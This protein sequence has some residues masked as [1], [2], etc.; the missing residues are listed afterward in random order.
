MNSEQLVKVVLDVL[1]EH[2][3][4]DIIKINIGEKSS[5]ADYFVVCSDNASKGT[6]GIR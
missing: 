2:K 4:L 6:C 5:I 3:A 1:K